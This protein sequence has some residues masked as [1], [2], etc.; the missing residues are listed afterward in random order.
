LVDGGLITSDQLYIALAYQSEKGGKLGQ[1]LTTLGFVDETRLTQTLSR[2]LSVPWVSLAHVEFSRE[3]VQLVPRRVAER[4]GLI[5]VFVRHVRNSTSFLYIAM[6]D[7]TNDV[8]LSKVADH[9]RLTVRPMIACPSDIRA[10]IKA[11]YDKELKV[12]Q[13]DG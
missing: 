10:A 7:P 1:I 11:H 4:F 3:L 12:G 5:P 6:E 2:Q 8:A 9:C 13:H